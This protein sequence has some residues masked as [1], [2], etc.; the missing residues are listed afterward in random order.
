M[1]KSVLGGAALALV[2]TGCA[3]YKVTVYGAPGGKT[4]IAPDLCGAVVACQDAGEK[5]CFYNATV[6]TSLD[7]KSTEINACKVAK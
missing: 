7:G 5:Q 4:Y 1:I 2:L 3:A 6:V